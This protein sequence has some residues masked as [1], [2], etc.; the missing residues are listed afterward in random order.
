MKKGKY[1]FPISELMENY[2]ADA[3]CQLEMASMNPFR[4]N[5][6]DPES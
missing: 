2:H 5:T 1:T 6:E 4:A 3:V